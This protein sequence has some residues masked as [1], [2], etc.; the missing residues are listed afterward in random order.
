MGERAAATSKLLHAMLITKAHPAQGAGDGCA[1][2]AGTR[3][4]SPGGRSRTRTSLVRATGSQ[5]C[6]A[7]CSTP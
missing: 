7:A 5:P 2:R 6:S 4:L 1:R 3:V